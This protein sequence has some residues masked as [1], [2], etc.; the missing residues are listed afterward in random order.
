M[1]RRARSRARECADTGARALARER[2]C[3]LA[4][5]HACALTLSKDARPRV[6]FRSP[7]GLPETPPASEA[8]RA[9]SVQC[10]AAQR[11]AAHSG[12]GG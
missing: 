10:K 3:A 1:R 4:R 8:P 7:L 5:R 9:N 11:K 6:Q 2:A 12:G